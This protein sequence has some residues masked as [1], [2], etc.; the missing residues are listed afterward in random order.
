MSELVMIRQNSARIMSTVYV[1]SHATSL[2]CSEFSHYKANRMQFT[3]S[4]L[5]EFKSTTSYFFY[6]PGIYLCN[7]TFL[8][9]IVCLLKNT[10]NDVS[11]NV[12]IYWLSCSYKNSFRLHLT[13]FQ[14]LQKD[15]YISQPPQNKFCFNATINYQLQARQNIK[16]NLKKPRKWSRGCCLFFLAEPRGL[17][18]FVPCPW[19][20]PGPPAVEVQSPDHWT[21]RKFKKRCVFSG[22]QIM[23]Y[24]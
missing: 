15:I 1:I 11:A 16:V 9:C 18:I 17:W 22:V 19:I 21:A 3:Q 6:F 5:L 20:E 4:F 24:L 12:P 2:T 14:S 8:V 10:Y 13:E 23:L 7:F